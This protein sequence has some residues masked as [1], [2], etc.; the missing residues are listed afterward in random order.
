MPKFANLGRGGAGEVSDLPG[1]HH[2][3]SVKLRLWMLLCRQ[4]RFS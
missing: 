1:G 2:G 3:P 4:P